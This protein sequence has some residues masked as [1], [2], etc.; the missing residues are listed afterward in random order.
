[1]KL[2][3]Q[4]KHSFSSVEWNERLRRMWLPILFACCFGTVIC[5]YTGQPKNLTVYEAYE[6]EVYL[7]EDSGNKA[8]DHVFTDE[9]AIQTEEIEE[10]AEEKIKAPLLTQNQFYAL[11][12]FFGLGYLIIGLLQISPYALTFRKPMDKRAWTSLAIFAGCLSLLALDSCW[13]A[14]ENDWSLAVRIGHWAVYT[15]L[16]FGIFIIPTFKHPSDKQMHRFFAET[17]IIGAL[18]TLSVGLT[19]LALAGLLEGIESLFG[20]CVERFLEN[21]AILMMLSVLPIL[22]VLLLPNPDKEGF[23]SPFAQKLCKIGGQFIMLPLMALYM[24]VLYAYIVKIGISWELPKGT[25]TWMTTVMMVELLITSFLL[26]PQIFGEAGRRF[27]RFVRK[28]LPWLALPPLALMTI[29]LVRR[30]NDYGWT[31]DRIYAVA[32]NAWCYLACLLLIIASFREKKVLTKLIA[33]FCLSFLLLS[34]I[35]GMNVTQFTQRLLT[36]QISQRI[37]QADVAFPD[38]AIYGMELAKWLDLLPVEQAEPIYSKM[39]YMWQTFGD[40]SNDQWI[41]A[42]YTDDGERA[43]SWYHWYPKTLNEARGEILLFGSKIDREFV[44]IPQGY[45][46]VRELAYSYHIEEDADGK[47]ILDFRQD[48]LRLTIDINSIAPDAPSINIPK[49]NGDMIVIYYLRISEY[50]YSG[51]MGLSH[52]VKGYIFSKQ[53]I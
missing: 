45:T 30:V 37:S 3:E 1:M 40:E 4:L 2:F 34:V 53:T 19:T 35:P 48:N 29:G 11:C 50:S 13:I 26:Y 31:V 42:E 6:E 9:D 27:W 22:L 33:S 21:M 8:E 7:V 36:R 10:P 24:L 23:A 41:K 14:S 17:I 12:L 32:F 15:S 18:L 44:D 20:I 25:V 46:K 52:D 43:R 16:F 5:I 49:A 47:F 51:N 39:H 28:A 38:T